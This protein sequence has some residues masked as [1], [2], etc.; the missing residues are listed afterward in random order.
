LRQLV[1]TRSG[2]PLYADALLAAASY[3]ELLA[4]ALVQERIASSLRDRD[5]AVRRA[6]LGIVIRRYLEDERLRPLGEKHLAALDSG[7]RGLLLS[8][9]SAEPKPTYKGRAASAIGLDVAFLRIEDIKKPKDL[10]AEEAV[11]GAV[12]DC[13]RDRDA[14]IRAAALDLVAKRKDVQ[15]S[16]RITAALDALREDPTPRLRRLSR[17]LVEGK[18][19]AAAFAEVDNAELLDFDFFVQRVQPILA[20][21]GADGMA[22]VM[23]HESHVV[24]RLQPPDYN[25]QFSEKRS[26]ENYRYALGVVDV[27]QPEKSLILIKPTRP[28][29]SAGDVQDYLAT[30][31]GGERWPGNEKSP[32]Y[33]TLLAW[34]RGARI[35]PQ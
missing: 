31:N 33:Q 35:A 29:D 2:K 9:V 27:A 4:D 3:P 12:A 20:K 19:T 32:E 22:C 30:H 6:A 23:C 25:D 16:A 26:R 21:R 18:D 8:E 1:E 11:L 28:S 5:A 10:L 24:L 14:N 34:I 17:A 7:L 13:L 15:H